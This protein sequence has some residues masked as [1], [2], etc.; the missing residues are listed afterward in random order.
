MEKQ[1]CEINSDK[2]NPEFLWYPNRACHVTVSLSQNKTKKT[3]LRGSKCTKLIE[4]VKM[5]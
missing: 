5:K 2:N 3:G 4:G 1:I